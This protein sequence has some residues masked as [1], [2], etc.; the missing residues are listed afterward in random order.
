MLKLWLVSNQRMYEMI[1]YIIRK[2]ERKMERWLIGTLI[3]VSL[4]YVGGG[5][6]GET[7]RMLKTYT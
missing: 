3:L 7:S 2:L 1:K 4:D 6:C 5:M